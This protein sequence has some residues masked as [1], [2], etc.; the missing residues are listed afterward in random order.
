MLE[1]GYAS[2]TCLNFVSIGLD[3]VCESYFLVGPCD[4]N[5]TR[6]LQE[7][8]EVSKAIEIV[9]DRYTE[10]MERATGL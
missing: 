8:E 6:A 9:G 1:D 2:Q 4:E 7:M 5:L 10:A 3:V